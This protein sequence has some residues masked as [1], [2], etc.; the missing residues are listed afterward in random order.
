MVIPLPANQDLTPMLWF[1]ITLILQMKVE[2][3][4]LY[5]HTV[6]STLKVGTVVGLGVAGINM[7]TVCNRK[8]TCYAFS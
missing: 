3:R 8:D 1:S 5:S 7:S 4:M 2:S 6:F